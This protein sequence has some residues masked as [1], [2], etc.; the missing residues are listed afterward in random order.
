MK[1]VSGRPSASLLSTDKNCP[2]LGKKLLFFRLGV[3]AFIL[4]VLQ[5]LYIAIWLIY[6]V[7]LLKVKKDRTWLPLTNRVSLINQVN[8][9]QLPC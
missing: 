4:F 5:S 9:G 3:S 7:R 2:R 6:T 8:E 1:T